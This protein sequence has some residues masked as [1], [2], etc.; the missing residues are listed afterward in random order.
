MK[1]ENFNQIG[2]RENNEDFLGHNDHCILV[3][4]GIGG[5]ASGEVA[6][7]YIVEY[8]L[9]KTKDQEEE[10]DKSYIQDL[11][12][13]AQTGLN[14]MLDD[15][16][17]LAKMGTTFTGLFFSEHAC[18][19]AHIGDSRI[20]LVRPSEKKIWHT[21]DHSLVGELVKNKDITRE[22]GRHHPMGNRISKAMMANEK[23]KTAKADILKIDQLQKGDLFFLCSDG[24]N[25]AWP[26]HELVELLCNTSINLE[27][28]T[29]IIK[30]KCS[31]L[32][33]DNNTAYLVEIEER[34]ELNFGNNEEVQWINLQE[35]YDDF[36]LHKKRL[37]EEEAQA[38]ED[39]MEAE[40]IVTP[41]DDNH[42]IAVA[43]QPE[44]SQ[45][46]TTAIKPAVAIKNETTNNNVQ[47]IANTSK[48]S[49]VQN[50]V[51]WLIIV[52]VAALVLFII[53]SGKEN[54]SESKPVPEKRNSI[55]I[56]NPGQKKENQ[57]KKALKEQ[58]NNKKN[59]ETEQ[60]KD[61]KTDPKTPDQKNNNNLEGA[62][63]GIQQPNQGNNSPATTENSLD[64][65]IDM[66]TTGSE[67]GVDDETKEEVEGLLK[68]DKK[69]DPTKTES[70]PQEA[71][72]DKNTTDNKAKQ[73]NKTPIKK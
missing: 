12:L 8:I 64:E 21:W 6:S 13:A 35:F 33:K 41:V 46:D 61:D 71:K 20:Y 9:R 5:H 39:E 25:E 43:S 47:H 53:L 28:K 1:K 15:K 66:N 38:K 44:Q 26:E 42:E 52:V 45:K 60:V 48:K 59:P 34:D 14:N 11:L 54:K 29:D 30:D 17:Q 7:K 3:C 67:G 36:K 56:H 24:V 51:L 19:A 69:K 62:S 32:S 31:Q 58:Q 27:Q 10:F 22:A 23:R 57:K 16:P 68:G 73:E 55:T 65:I 4:D 40:I 63:E 70:N 72:Q 37:A 49:I 18:F 2:T 50:K